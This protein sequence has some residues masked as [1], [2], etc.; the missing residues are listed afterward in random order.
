MWQLLSISLN[1][2]MMLNI[3]LISLRCE[4]AVFEFFPFIDSI[5]VKI[6]CFLCNFILVKTGIV[7]WL[8]G[9][10]PLA[11]SPENILSVHC[12]WK[13]LTSVSNLISTILNNGF[14]PINPSS[15]C[16]MIKWCHFSAPINLCNLG[17][18]FCFQNLKSMPKAEV[19]LFFLKKNRCCQIAIQNMCWIFRIEWVKCHT[20]FA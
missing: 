14:L 12:A 11:F 15:I 5:I 2:V 20:I 16:P 9:H 19:N 18:N 17:F 1:T 3:K 4:C 8:F 10:W 13:T 6:H 7:W